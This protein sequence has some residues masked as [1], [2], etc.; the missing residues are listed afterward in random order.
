MWARDKGHLLFPYFIN[1]V[2]REREREE[3]QYL[4]VFYPSPNVFILFS[5]LSV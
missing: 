5:S 3:A 4:S 1:G 2:K